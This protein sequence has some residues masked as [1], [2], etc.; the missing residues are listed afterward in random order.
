MVQNIIT[1]VSITS[2]YNVFSFVV[3][4]SGTSEPI[5]EEINNTFPVTWTC[6]RF[7]TGIYKVQSSAVALPTVEGTWFIGGGRNF[8]GVEI[9]VYYGGSDNFIIQTR[10]NGTLTDGLLTRTA[11]EVRD[12]KNS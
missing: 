11:F 7:S 10:L 5:I 4:Q 9:N 8:G 12:L 6:S 1:E 2:A 3:T